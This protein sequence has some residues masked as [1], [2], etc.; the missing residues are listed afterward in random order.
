[1]A[2]VLPSTVFIA[3]VGI[4]GSVMYIEYGGLGRGEVGLKGSLAQE[5]CAT[6]SHQHTE[7]ASRP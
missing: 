5:I 4:T 1:M 6:W 2:A 3:T 7:Q